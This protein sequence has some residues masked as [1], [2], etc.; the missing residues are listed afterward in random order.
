VF[1]IDD[2]IAETMASDSK[3]I[4]QSL[5]VTSPSVAEANHAAC[6]GLNLNRRFAFSQPFE[7]YYPFAFH[8]FGRSKGN[9]FPYYMTLR[10]YLVHE[11]CAGT[12]RAGQTATIG[13]QQVRR[14]RTQRT[15]ETHFVTFY[16]KIK[17]LYP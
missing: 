12:L 17:C 3:A 2:G 9:S 5:S 14:S 16:G 8:G 1:A 6:H 11:E 13:L 4:E 7:A 10:G 15:T